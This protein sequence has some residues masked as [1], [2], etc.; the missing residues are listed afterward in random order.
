MKCIC[1]C[2]AKLLW[3]HMNSE[4]LANVANANNQ[5]LAFAE[6]FSASAGDLIKRL[7]TSVRTQYIFM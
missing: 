7:L 2:A 3:H 4:T 5:E 1:A 6:G